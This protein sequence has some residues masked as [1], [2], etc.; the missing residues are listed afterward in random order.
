MKVLIADDSEVIRTAIIKSLQKL[1]NIDTMYEAKEVPQAIEILNKYKPDIALIDIK[2]PGGS[3]F[4]V[5][6][7]A[8][9]KDMNCLAIMLTNYTFKHYENKSMANGADYFFD[10]ALDFEKV[11]ATISEFINKKAN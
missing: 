9:Q 7:A 10:K 4:D 8:K 2:M 11:F 6:K 3:G 1:K 5:L